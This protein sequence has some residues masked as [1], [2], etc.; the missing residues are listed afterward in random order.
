MMNRLCICALML[1]ALMLAMG[2]AACLAEA[3]EGVAAADVAPEAAPTTDADPG[4]A[5]A[6]GTPEA[7]VADG[8]PA[9][10]KPVLYVVLADCGATLYGKGSKNAVVTR[11]GDPDGVLL[12]LI[13]AAP[14]LLCPEANIAVFG[15]HSELVY[16]QQVDAVPMDDG[17]AL[18]AQVRTLLDVGENQRVS[19]NLAGALQA[20]DEGWLTGMGWAE[21]YDCRLVILTG[22]AMY[23]ASEKAD[24]PTVE[25]VRQ[26]VEALTDRGVTVRAFGY[27]LAASGALNEKLSPEEAAQLL[28]TADLFGEGA[29]IAAA[30]GNAG[31]SDS[32]RFDYVEQLL[33][34]FAAEGGYASSGS[35][36]GGR[37]DRTEGRIYVLWNADA[38]RFQGMKGEKSCGLS[39]ET[40]LANANKCRCYDPVAADGVAA[41]PEADPVE[42]ALKSIGAALDADGDGA[43]DGEA[44]RAGTDDSRPCPGMSPEGFTVTSTDPAVLAAEAADGMLALS[45]QAAGEATLTIAPADAPDRALALKAAVRDFRLAWDF[46]TEGTLQAD[47]KPARLVACPDGTLQATLERLEVDGEWTAVD[48]SVEDNALNAA[49]KRPGTYRVTAW[50]ELDGEKVG[51]PEERSFTAALAFDPVA[52]VALVAPYFRE[53]PGQRVALTVGGA[54][55][56]LEGFRAAAEPASLAEVYLDAGKGCL[57]IA[58]GQAGTGR[59]LLTDEAGGE[60]LSF[61]LKVDSLTKKPMLWIL[62]VA[63]PVCLIGL[64]AMVVILISKLRNR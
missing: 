52:D 42:R 36:S 27:D 17:E 1:A 64:T 16:S 15:Y 20:L 25:D 46:E 21:T 4:E 58:P 61:N 30:P 28:L 33:G 56:E 3:V 62:A 26:R 18:C 22:G 24:N 23:F 29:Y 49:L 63:I 11:A 45:P 41:E 50:A 8:V 44:L 43:L 19:S 47:L 48:A 13:A 38:R 53:Q 51:E 55:V 34:Y 32:A 5:P 7:A 10:G 2:F 60:L 59:V 31:S 12:S 37:E 57:Y 14:P 54:P 35:P 6:D 40:T 9:G 39:P